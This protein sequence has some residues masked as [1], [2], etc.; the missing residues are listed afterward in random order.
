MIKTGE[1]KMVCYP[2][3][4]TT[5]RLYGNQKLYMNVMC[6]WCDYKKKKK[7]SISANYNTFIS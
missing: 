5:R 6:V 3:R 4:I 7:I 1:T 2:L